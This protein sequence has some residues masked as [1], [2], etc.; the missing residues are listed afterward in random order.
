[1]ANSPHKGEGVWGCS[2]RRGRRVTDVRDKK[3]TGNQSEANA[4]EFTPGK[5]ADERGCRPKRGCMQYVQLAPLREIH[6]Y[7]THSQ[8]RH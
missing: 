3:Y 2:S 5:G 7:T 8:I 1:M 6:K 4:G